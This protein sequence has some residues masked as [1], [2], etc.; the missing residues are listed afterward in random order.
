MM[1]GQMTLQDEAGD[2]ANWSAI[3][4]RFRDVPQLSVTKET[5]TMDHSVKQL[6]DSQQRNLE[7]QREAGLEVGAEWSKEDAEYR[8]LLRIA[9]AVEE[10]RREIDMQTLCTI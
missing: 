7:T 4:S 1:K 10:A 9:K 8:E 2:T 6:C 3:L 5:A